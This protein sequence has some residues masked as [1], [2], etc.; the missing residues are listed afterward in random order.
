MITLLA[1]L[2]KLNESIER[3]NKRINSYIKSTNEK[4][5]HDVR[6]SIRRFNAAFLSLPKKYT[7]ESALLSKYNQMANEFFK[8][9]SKIRDYDII[10]QK[11]G[12]YPQSKQRDLVIETIKKN[13]QTNL[14]DAKILANSVKE[15]ASQNI[16]EKMNITEKELQKRYKKV[17]VK[18]I[19]KIELD[20]P[21][22]ITDASQIQK[23][24]ELRKN[25]KKMRYMLELLSE[26]NEK[27][28]ELR[29]IFEKIQNYLGSIHDFDIIISY[30]RS[31]DSNK[32]IQDIMN[33]EIEKRLLRYEEFLTFSKRR[34]HI[35]SD[36][37]LIKT[38]LFIK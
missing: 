5:I 38:K 22:V 27:A 2:I 15:L 12:S 9:N 7:T 37:F 29:K 20:F 32:E 11:L 14:E 13:R 36:S 21:D 6:T 16:I 23:L 26:E 30:L 1:Y 8:I 33:N 24:H 4:N 28:V 3:L 10:V 31:F 19:S 25:S 35:S 34:L 17:L 18:L